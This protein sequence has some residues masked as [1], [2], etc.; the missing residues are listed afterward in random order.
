MSTTGFASWDLGIPKN[1]KHKL[2]H[3][4]NVIG[5]NSAKL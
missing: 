2:G 1:D 4:S 5:Q 3:I